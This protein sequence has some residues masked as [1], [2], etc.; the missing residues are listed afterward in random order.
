MAFVLGVAANLGRQGFDS[1][2][3]RDAPD[4][5]RGRTFARFEVRLQLSWVIGA[6][7]PVLVRPSMAV[8]LYLLGG[9]LAL[10]AVF[11]G[12]G[13][14]AA[15]RR[16]WGQWSSV[17]PS[18]DRVGEDEVMPLARQLLDTASWLA[19][20]GSRRQAVVVAASAVD[21]VRRTCQGDEPALTAALLELEGLV[22]RATDRS[23]LD[24]EVVDRALEIATDAVDRYCERDD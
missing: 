13:A 1:L 19:D 11:Y 15:V 22:G 4:A 2:V 7:L 3:Q 9:V 5:E 21:A 16:H 14:R 20:R 17:L 18:V 24:D 10:G 12:T 23:D 8:G 6:L